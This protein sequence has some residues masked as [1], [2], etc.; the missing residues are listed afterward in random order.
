[1]NTT[2]HQMTEWRR[3]RAE[4]LPLLQARAVSEAHLSTASRLAVLFGETRTLVILALALALRA[5][6]TGSM[7]TDLLG[8]SAL[9]LKAE[10]NLQELSADALRILALEGRR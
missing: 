5:P 9:D 4:L 6:G 10:W 3:L 8:P 7:R 2:M 1:M